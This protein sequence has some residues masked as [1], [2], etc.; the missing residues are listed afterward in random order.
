MDEEGKIV[1]RDGPA[2]IRPGLPGGPDV[3]E[4]VAVHRSFADLDKTANWLDQPVSAIEIA[5]RYHERHRAEID[6][7]IRGNELAAEAA[8]YGG[9]STR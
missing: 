8:R 1:L 2:G 6:D 5:L 9:R 4:V 7:W 3:W